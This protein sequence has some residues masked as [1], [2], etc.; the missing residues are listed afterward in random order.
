MTSYPDQPRAA[1]PVPAEPGSISART[2]AIIAGIG[3][4]VI[5]VGAIFANFVVLEGMVVDGDPAETVANIVDDEAVFRIGLI[6]FLV[7][8]VVDVVIA[9]ALWIVFKAESRELS[10]LSAWMRLT[11]TVMLGVALVFFFI[12]LQL[13]SGADWLGAFDQGQLDAQ[14]LVALDAFDAAWLIGLAAFGVHLILLGVLL[15][16]F[17]A[18]PW[19]LGVLLAIAGTAYILDTVAHGVLA[20]Y[21]DYADVFLAI[22]AVPSIA[23]E[24]WFTFWLLL[25]GGRS[26]RAVA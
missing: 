25:R 4:L 13:V 2:A 17:R 20:D 15:V 23:G 16:R 8:F 24:L 9:W 26:E 7:I 19:V 22:V 10:R 21:E 6:A 3:Y 1:E 5:F 14:V 12:V 18:G 11:Y